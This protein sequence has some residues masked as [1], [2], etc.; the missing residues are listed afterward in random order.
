MSNVVRKIW[1][2][3]SSQDVT[4]EMELKEMQEFVGGCIEFVPSNIPRRKLVINDEG[5]LE[6]LPINDAASALVRGDI[7][8]L[9][10]IR[11]NALLVK[12]S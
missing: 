2:D 3:G 10:G 12:A 7:I 6:N 9:G 11:G 5:L 4:C 8:T 1:T